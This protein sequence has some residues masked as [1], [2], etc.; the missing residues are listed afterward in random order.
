MFATLPQHIASHSKKPKQVASESLST[1]ARGS[2]KTGVR[3]L[4]P[5]AIGLL[6]MPPSVDAANCVVS[7]YKTLPRGVPGAQKGLPHKLSFDASK[8]A[9][10]LGLGCEI[11]YRD[12]KAT[13]HDTLEDFAARG[14][15]LNS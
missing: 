9:R 1:R 10:V 14:W 12:M 15:G 2:G 6:H 8:A 13:I 3:P 7:S 5:Y 11:P 4:F